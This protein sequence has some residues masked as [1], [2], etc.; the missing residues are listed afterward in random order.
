MAESLYR[1]TL[2]QSVRDVLLGR[3]KLLDSPTHVANGRSAMV[4]NPAWV[5]VT[6][7]CKACGDGPTKTLPAIQEQHQDLYKYK[8]GSIKPAPTL[9]SV[10][11]T[12]G[13]TWGLAKKISA[14][15]ECYTVTDFK[16]IQKAF[17]LPG[18]EIS[19]KFGYKNSWGVPKD[20]SHT[21]KGFKVATF[22]FNTTSEGTW[23]CTFEA[24]SSG[25]AIKTL[26]MQLVVCNGCDANAGVGQSA[27]S[28]PLKYLV[29]EN[30]DPNP[31]K[32][33]AQLIAAD[34]Q[35]NGRYSI[36]DVEDGDVIDY[37]VNYSPDPVDDKSAALVVYNGDHLRGFWGEVA[38]WGGGI[39]R[40]WGMGDSEVENANNQVFL[41]VGYII[42]RIINDQLLRA[43]ACG[44]ISENGDRADFNT[45]RVN[46]HPVYSKCKIAAGITSGDPTSVLLLGDANYKNSSGEGKNFDVDCKNLGKVK[47]ALGG[48]EVNIKNILVH[49]NVVIAAFNN[50]TKKREAES[51]STGVKDTKDEVVN[52]IDFFEGIS[53]HISAAVGGA[54]ALRIVEHPDD[55]KK[56]LVVD[57]NYGVTDKLEC[58]V[59][60]PIDGDGSTR[61][62]NVQSSVG[63]EEYKAAMYVGT[64]K[65]GD[66][67]AALRG[68]DKNLK[69]QR[70]KEHT[71]AKTDKD[72]LIKS[73]GNLGKNNFNGN[74]INALK[75]IMSRLHRNNQTAGDIETIHYPGLSISATLDGVWGFEPGMAISATSIPKEWIDENK[76]YF[77][78]TRVQHSFTESDWST[79]ID[80]IL[81]Y[82]P[83]VIPIRL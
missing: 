74:E 26:D 11:I 15:I 40:S 35:K 67:V 22:A 16:E 48:G 42:N 36:D 24:V 1:R 5:Q 45:L 77:M 21:L 58:I 19:A 30:L 27:N 34:A 52:I 18:N 2:N 7:T 28:G 4:R 66:P 57:Q 83:N 33:V 10:T 12:N 39:L 20:I 54:I 14:E 59:L 53:D 78:I 81:A 62:C 37:F 38:A 64:S 63:S 9:R 56:L 68:C 65:K 32:G 71:K 23:L 55:P 79:S 46:F 43:F 41:S 76:A 61:E 44:I 6:G 75:S 17:L 73:P 82:Y 70:E 3:K 25:T 47:S 60:D 69:Q 49:R 29:G 31:V 80:G 72:A 13:G 8:G 50:A 51:D